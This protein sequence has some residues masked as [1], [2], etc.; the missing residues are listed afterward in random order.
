[1]KKAMSAMKAKRKPRKKGMKIKKKKMK[2]Y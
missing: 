1:M 2:G